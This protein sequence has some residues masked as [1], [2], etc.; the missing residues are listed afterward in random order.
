MSY[1]FSSPLKDCTSSINTRPSLRKPKYPMNMEEDK[2]LS[3]FLKIETENVNS[4][5]I[6]VRTHR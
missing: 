4:I 3:R 5:N 1:E 6:N 2:N